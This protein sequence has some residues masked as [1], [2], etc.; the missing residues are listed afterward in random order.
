MGQDLS[1]IRLGISSRNIDF[2]S[3]ISFTAELLRESQ[4]R[5]LDAVYLIREDGFVLA[6][7]ESP[8]APDLRIPE[9]DVLSD[10]DT[11][12]V[13]FQK[14]SDINFLIAMTKLSNSPNTY[15]YAG[16]ALRSENQV[17]SSISGIENA[18]NQ[19]S[20]FNENQT[21]MN[22]IFFLTFILSLIHISEPTRPY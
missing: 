12:R 4:T 10:L 1:D 9:Y 6:R 8:T 20:R 7:A 11:S 13:A 18:T 16:Q 22:Q 5:N 14:R 15:L 17:L 2:G 3:R 19:I 21:R